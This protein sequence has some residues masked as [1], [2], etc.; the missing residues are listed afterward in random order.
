MKKQNTRKRN[1]LT[2]IICV[3]KLTAILLLGTCLQVSATVYSQKITLSEKNVLLEKVFKE[4]KKQSDYLFW[5]ENKVLR[6]AGKVSIEVSNA[7]LEE[8]LAQCF[9]NQPLTYSIVDKTVVVKLLEELTITGKVTDSEGKPLPSATVM[10]KGTFKG[11]TTNA[12]GEY[13]ITVPDSKTILVFSY[14]GFAKQEV[15]VGNKTSINVTLKQAATE[16]GEVTINAG[17]YK[18]KKK[19][20]TS[21]IAQLKAEAIEQQPVSNPLLAMQGRMTGVDIISSSGVIGSPFRIQ[22]RGLNSLRSDGN[23][24]LIL[25][26]GV[27]YPTESLAYGGLIAGY[28]H[29][30]NYIN[31]NDIEG[32]EVLKDAD[33]TAIYGSRGANGVILIRTKKARAGKTKVAVNAHTGF[34][35][36]TNKLEMLNLEQY[37]AMREE[38]F[39]NDGRE[40]STSDYDVNG[41]WDQTRETDW[42]DEFLS[43][44]KKMYNLHATVSGGTGKTNFLVSTNY[45]KETT[46]FSKDFY[47]QKFSTNFKINHRSENE[48]FNIYLSGVY[49]L[50]KLKLNSF[51]LS[52]YTLTLAPNAPALYNEDGSLNWEEGTWTNPLSGIF[53]P[54]D[55]KAR[56]LVAN[57]GVSYE[58]FK[59]LTL[60]TTVG[61]TDVRTDRIAKTL[62]A[63]FNPFSSWVAKPIAN[64]EDQ[65]STTW[66]IEPQ[67][68]YIRQ[69]GKGVFT[70]LVGFTFQESKTESQ[71][72]YATEYTSDELL[73]N[74]EAAGATDIS[75]GN[76]QYRFSS[77]FGRLNYNLKDTYILNFTGRRDGSSRFGPGKKFA[78]FMAIGGAWIFSKENFIKDNFSFLNYGKLRVSYGSTG[79]DAIG[80]YEYVELWR[81]VRYL[82]DNTL[83]VSPNN[84][85]NEDF[86]WEETKKF[87]VGMD[88]GLFNDRVNP[89][90]SYYRHES[91]NQLVG[92]P[93]PWI[94]GF[95]R[96]QSNLPAL[97]RNTGLEIECST[98]NIKT[99]DFEWSTNFNI[100]VP[101]NKL[102]TFDGIEKTNYANR[103]VVGKSLFV[104]K[105]YL[106]DG[107]DPET[108][109]AT[110]KDLN[111]DG[112]INSTNDREAFDYQKKFYGGLT[113]TIHYKGFTLDFT[114]HF[115]KQTGLNHTNYFG[116]PGTFANQPVIVLENRWQQPGDIT[117]VPRF[118]QTGAAYSAYRSFYRY[119]D[120]TLTDASFIRL[121]NLS[122]AYQFPSS[123]LEK[124]KLKSLRLYMQAQNLFVITGYKGWDPET[125]YNLPPLRTITFGMNITL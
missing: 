77:V 65:F 6:Q 58:L 55:S 107:V 14:V 80:D 36:L 90:I 66:N 48:K 114:F 35:S 103:Y 61:V 28:T 38:A 32:I 108:G 89:S 25:I 82:Y 86:A 49:T 62:Y 87:E 119:S 120:Q 47:D 79:S 76:S 37:L 42:Q 100:T 95:N 78:N 46:L 123:V 27:P 121:Q 71:G 34:G 106:F 92:D 5:Y 3:M 75:F 109:I 83:G 56:N 125:G 15:L 50:N 84:L 91:S 93:L 39:E 11:I 21:N 53:R 68:E 117:D 74:P 33:A 12:D 118:T 45:R 104:R 16:L 29:P 18:M 24:P 51:Q 43:G 44:S 19:T 94:T 72:I 111:E 69:L 52:R 70:A 10:I 101:D 23:D 30:L 105:L 57:L 20:A 22:I 96:I 59:G 7:T 2:K 26:D 31:P 110:F 60:K 98:V 102:V 88:F 13:S 1:V 81:P 116:A 54:S 113:N 85:F 40:P 8:V 115:V 122:L 64:F 67:A 17:Y 63:A 9:A 124:F 97:V 112:R 41:T 73:N 99:K 4:I